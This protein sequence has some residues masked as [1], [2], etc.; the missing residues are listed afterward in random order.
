[1]TESLLVLV[2]GAKTSTDNMYF[3]QPVD[4]NHLGH[5]PYKCGVE[6]ICG[7]FRLISASD[8]A[9]IKLLT[10][11]ESSEGYRLELKSPSKK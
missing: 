5:G 10:K 1:M 8:L 3:I 2:K 6:M 11:R 4:N 7:S 9:D